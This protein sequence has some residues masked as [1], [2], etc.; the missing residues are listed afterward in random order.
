MEVHRNCPRGIE[1]RLYLNTN[2]FGSTVIAA[3]IKMGLKRNLYYEIKDTVVEEKYDG[4]HAYKQ[5]VRTKVYGLNSN[6][7]IRRK[8]IDILIERVE[9]HKDKIISPIIYNELLG[10][11]I[12]RNGKV[13]HSASTHDDQIFSMLM[14]LYMWYEGV[15]MAERFGLKKTSI[16]TDQDVDEQLD[17]YND[18]SIEIV[19]TF[20]T[21]DEV[22][23]EIQQS[24]NSAIRAGGQLMQDFLDQRHASEQE[25]LKALFNTPLGAKAYRNKFNI[26]DGESID[27]YVGTPGEYNI[28]M[29][30]FDGFYNPTSSTFTDYGGFGGN[31][32]IVTNQQTMPA[33]QAFAL[34]DEDYS[35]N[36]HFNF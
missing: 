21:E 7:E 29:S 17:Y 14:A 12:K 32:D 5:K 36:D 23:G 3:L 26:P 30:V 25:Q 16:K 13:E 20:T 2:G 34:E 35:Y 28:P 18:N 27:K 1:L 33:D 24:L 6:K 19:D 10:M 15:D 9:N 11:E 4:V 22:D 8:L 31:T